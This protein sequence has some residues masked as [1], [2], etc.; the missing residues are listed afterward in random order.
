M[1]K[2]YNFYCSKHGHLH[3]EVEKPSASLLRKSVY[4]PWCDRK[5]SIIAD[6]KEKRTSK[7]L[8]IHSTEVVVQSR[9]Q[10]AQTA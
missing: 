1:S 4:C 7:F 5:L 3:I 10:T 9:A 2:E 8:G 6:D